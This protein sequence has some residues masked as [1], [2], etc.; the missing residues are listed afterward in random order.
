MING[1]QIC[2]FKL[3]DPL[4]VAGRQIDVVEL[5]WPGEKRY[6][7]EGW[8]HIEVVLRGDHQTLGMRAMAFRNIELDRLVQ[9]TQRG[10]QVSPNY[11]RF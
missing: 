8:E 10:C 5:P 9:V 7:H 11:F 3:H 1:R 6:R 2:L 4:V